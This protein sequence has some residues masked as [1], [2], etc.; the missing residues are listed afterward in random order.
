VGSVSAAKLSRSPTGFAAWSFVPTVRTSSMRLA[1]SGC[2]CVVINSRMT[3]AVF[4]A[5]AKEPWICLWVAMGRALSGVSCQSPAPT[6]QR[7]QR[8]Y[9]L[10]SCVQYSSTRLL[11]FIAAV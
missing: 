7:T 11:R 10:R 5:Q 2:R 9:L 8:L 4:F 3:S 1:A 6:Q